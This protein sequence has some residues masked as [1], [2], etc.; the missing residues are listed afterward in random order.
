MEGDQQ[1]KNW[2]HNAPTIAP[3][4]ENGDAVTV[5]TLTII[6]PTGIAAANGATVK[7]QV[8]QTRAL[9]EEF[10]REFLINEL[11]GIG[12]S[13]VKILMMYEKFGTRKLDNWLCSKSQNDYDGW[14]IEMMRKTE[15]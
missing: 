12:V 4:L 14:Q 9:A 11:S 10:A 1:D 3:A 7:T 8:F 6:I 5:Y 2:E 15:Q 13:L